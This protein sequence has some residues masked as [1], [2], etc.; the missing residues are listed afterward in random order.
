MKKTWQCCEFGDDAELSG[1]GAVGQTRLSH[2][3]VASVCLYLNAARRW[4]FMMWRREIENNGAQ[5]TGGSTAG[6]G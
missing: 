2:S 4:Y 5:L 1:D 6:L 3:S